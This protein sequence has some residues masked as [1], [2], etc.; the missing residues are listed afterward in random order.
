M[1]VNYTIFYHSTCNLM[2][3]NPYFN[4]NKVDIAL[5]NSLCSTNI[6]SPKIAQLKILAANLLTVHTN[7]SNY[8]DQTILIKL[9]ASWS[10]NGHF[11]ISIRIYTGY[12]YIMSRQPYWLNFNKKYH[13]SFF[14]LLYLFSSN[15]A[16]E[17]FVF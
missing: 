16:M 1:I 2:S 6:S 7:F 4:D 17:I 14:C 10:D 9:L 11:Y 5:C 12:I 3:A 15:M 13:L 8:S